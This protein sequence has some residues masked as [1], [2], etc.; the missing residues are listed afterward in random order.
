MKLISRTKFVNLEY[1]IVM[2]YILFLTHSIACSTVLVD[3]GEGGN[4]SIGSTSIFND[5]NYYQHVAGKITVEGYVVVDT[6]EAWLNRG[7]TGQVD[8]KIYADDNN[9]PG[10]ALASKTYDIDRPLTYSWESFS[11]LNVV[12]APGSYWIAI[13]VPQ[14]QAS[15]NT[16]MPQG[17]ATPLTEYAYFTDGN[18][19]W[20]RV[21]KDR[22]A[23]SGFRIS[24]IATDEIPVGSFARSIKGDTP[25]G[26]IGIGDYI[27]GGIDETEAK[28]FGA[29]SCCRA[30]TRAGLSEVGLDA[31]AAASSSTEA[32]SAARALTF[33]SYYNAGE[34]DLTFRVN[35][36]LEGK[37]KEAPFGLPSAG[38]SVRAGVYVYDS[39]RFSD[40][41]AQGLNGGLTD[42]QF[43]MPAT[44]DEVRTAGFYSIENV[45][46][47]GMLTK[48]NI[49]QH[50]TSPGELLTFDL[51]TDLVTLAPHESITIVFDLSA[52]SKGGKGDGANFYDTLSPATHLFTDE[53]DNP[54]TTI[55]PMGNIIQFP[56]VLFNSAITNASKK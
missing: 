25:G 20:V 38:S 12:L 28:F 35:A 11:E 54:V 16:G 51:S 26:K 48:N 23:S 55:L 10:V 34:G 3:T 36:V 41:V 46:F 45:V 47:D 43:F 6:I 33:R 27:R 18:D 50:Y 15:F 52:Y 4:S 14:V 24:G 37:F 31:G 2:F 56:W 19:R 29:S 49:S 8:I 7:G 40:Q 5:G 21:S 13:E 22:D 17:A 1:A 53:T 32:W 9:L 42:K 39:D 44:W 30:V